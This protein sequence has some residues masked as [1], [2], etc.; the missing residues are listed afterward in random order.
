MQNDRRITLLKFYVISR[1]STHVSRLSR[2]YLKAVKFAR[3]TTTINY[4]KLH[5]WRKVV[6][7]LTVAY[8][9]FHF[10][11]RR[12]GIPASRNARWQQRNSIRRLTLRG[13]RDFWCALTSFTA[14][15]S[16][17]PFRGEPVHRSAAVGSRGV[18]KSKMEYWIKRYAIHRHAHTHI[19]TRI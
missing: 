6:M 9:R 12:H 7:R 4:A 15:W 10:G 5:Y 2:S 1:V 18:S 8:V 14:L 17:F 19:H 3:I 13:R 11:L 16:C